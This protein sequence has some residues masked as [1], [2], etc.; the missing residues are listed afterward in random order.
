MEKPADRPLPPR[1]I[2][3]RALRTFGVVC[4]AG[5]I[6]A[7]ARTLN[8]SQPSVSNTIALLEDRLGVVLFKRGRTGIELTPEGEALRRRAIALDSL[9]EKAV[10]DV[11]TAS[12]GIAGP[13]RIGGTPGALVSLLPQTLGALEAKFG[14]FTLN[15]VE[16][17]DQQLMEMLRRGEIELA[18]VTTEMEEPPPDLHERTISRDPFA[19]IVG[20]RHSGLPD[21]ISLRDV[22]HFGW[23]LP[24]ALGAFRRQVDALFIAAQ[25][26]VPRHAIRCDSLLTTKAIVREGARVTVLP[27]Q[28]AAAELSIG[29]LRAITIAEANFERSVGVRMLADGHPS[30]MAAALLTALLDDT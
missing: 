27:R 15:V 19:L 21:R 22:Q 28:V 18:F 5:T 26:A 14:P 1:P 16:R 7:A 11:E 29:A 9:L 12:A 13:L 4:A 30:P 6:S 3:P 25:V 17:N 23:V 24:E 20:P 2:D 10:E 8:I